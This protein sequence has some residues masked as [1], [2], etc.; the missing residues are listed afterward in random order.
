[1]LN[2]LFI[3]Y[4]VN[5]TWK[6]HRWSG[7]MPLVLAVTYLLANALFRNSGGRYILPVDWAVL[8]YFSIGLAQFT[9]AGIAYLQD[10]PVV[11]ELSADHHRSPVQSGSILH[12]PQ[13]YLAVI[14]LFLLGC[15]AP[16]LEAGVPRR[17]DEAR[18]TAMVSTLLHS[19]QLSQR[20]RDDL[21]ALLSH[22]GNAYAGRLLYP[23]Y[24]APDDGD[25]GVGKI[26][27][28]APKP[29][30]RLGFYLAGSQNTI[31]SLPVN[32]K[33]SSLPNGQDVLVIGC[34]PSDL[35]LVARFSA[36]GDIDGLYL[37]SFLPSRLA[38]PLP[39]IPVD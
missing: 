15:A 8:V 17:Y 4:G 36:E 9:T 14:G 39:V 38:C 28:F 7:V 2:L 12:S 10:A 5:E 18:R 34:N 11:A 22:G 26:H 1:V 21:Y 13:F 16:V 24:F 30:P 29:Y 20:Q 27:P 19:E 25:P 6:R 35:L 23:R 31:L 37:R 32:D 3:A 33:P